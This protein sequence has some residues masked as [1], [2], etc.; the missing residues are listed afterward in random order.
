MPLGYYHVVPQATSPLDIVVGPNRKCMD[1]ATMCGG[2]GLS[3]HM[4]MI[5]PD[6]FVL[7]QILRK[8]FP[9]LH[10]SQ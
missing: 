7:L 10:D 8:T 1:S 6:Y 4:A 9:S 3:H 5:T 2:E